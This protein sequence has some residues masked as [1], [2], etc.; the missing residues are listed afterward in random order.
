MPHALA[1][2]LFFQMLHHAK[3]QVTEKATYSTNVAKL[4]AVK[5]I[6]CRRAGYSI[7]MRGSSTYC[8]D[9]IAKTQQKTALSP[10]GAVPGA[11]P[12]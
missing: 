4:R 7:L 11:I 6:S 2:G 12:E 8:K 9:V 10:A 3:P 1:D 5:K